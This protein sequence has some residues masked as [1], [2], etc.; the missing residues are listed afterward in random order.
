MFGGND[1]L[2]RIMSTETVKP[3]NMSQ[4]LARF[5]RYFKPYW[6]LL[7]VISFFVIITTWAQVISPEL[8]GQT[9]DCYL[10][11]SAAASF[12][13]FPG[14][15]T[16]ENA[17]TTSNCWI[18]AQGDT[19]LSQQ[20]QRIFQDRAYAE[21]QMLAGMN[22]DQRLN[23]L[24]NIIII[25]V[26]LY[27]ASSVLT[28][29][30]FFLMSWVGQHVLTRMRVQLFEQLHALSLSYYAEH[31]VGDLMSRITNDTET[32]QQ[33]F[34]FALINVLSGFLLIF[35][36][37]Y[38]MLTLSLPYALISLAV[39]P[40][41]AVAT[42]WFSNQA[43]KAF[44]RTRLEM[45]SVNAELQESI[46]SV[47]EIQAFNREAE[48]IE[49]FMATNAANRDANVRA[50][51]FTSALAPTLEGLGYL[52]LGIVTLAGG[53]A[54]LRGQ[55]LMG[56]TISL[57]LIVTFIG[58]VQRFN[59]P[60][61]QI[62]VLWTNIQ[63]AVAGGERIFTLI[64][65]IPAIQD[66]RG[67]GEM[68]AIIGQVTFS[69]VAA[70]YKEGQSVLKDISFT[71]EPGQTIAIVGPTGAGKTTLIN[72][73]PRFYDVTGGSV[74]ID[75]HD[76][77]DV[78]TES[79]R[80]QIGIVLQDSFLFSTSVMENIRFGRPDATDEDVIA[81]AKL[82]H[83]DSF[84]ARLPQKY[85]TVLGERGSGLSQGQ[86]Q[87]ISIARAA[88]ADPRILILDEATS[89]VDTR[90]ERLIQRA[91]DQLL[92]GRTS[93]VIAHRLSTIRNADVLL[94]LRDGEIIERGKHHD[95]L[96]AKGFYYDLYMSQFRREEEPA[97]APSSN[98]SGSTAL[99]PA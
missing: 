55:T 14:A 26:G 18:S 29:L 91:L 40:L 76:V 41:M 66:K 78:R 93:F 8:I 9:V 51:S 97:P 65:E 25:I 83:A 31:E 90:T 70:G 87:L 20:I 69:H 37:A 99:S 44:R 11:P 43:R 57:G 89:S 80:R 64:D 75:G 5:G 34:S 7:L 12:G 32:I 94:V 46:S 45:G 27:V 13:N 36:V 21:N 81:A 86:R 60:I 53:L 24:L 79:L 16:A 52:A 30:T 19:S 1:G 50:V 63:N 67:A 84:I 95:L 54:L 33:A 71:A 77:R 6:P 42:V 10:T 74:A 48:N 82:A 62:A 98:G 3:T 49:N 28:G 23:G 15:P 39:V 17:G 59:Q 68:P 72:L 61:Q 35:W 4:T 22:G 38:N 85:D 92:Q 73:I 96:A 56:T 2:R 88:L 58:Y 47:R